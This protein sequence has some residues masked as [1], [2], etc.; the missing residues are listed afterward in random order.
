MEYEPITDFFTN[1]LIYGYIQEKE[2][3]EMDK[4]KK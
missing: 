4:A 2:R 3:M 1:L